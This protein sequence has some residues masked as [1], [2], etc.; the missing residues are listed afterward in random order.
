M[1]R[2]LNIMQAAEN[3]VRRLRQYGFEAYW[4]GGCV[5]D[6]LLEREPK[7]FDVATSAP[8][9][10]I[11]RIFSHTRQVGAKFG[12][13]MVCQG[14]F[15]IETATFRTDLDY[16]D[17][18]HPEQVVFTTAEYDAQRRDFTINGLFYDPLEQK[19]IDYV[20]GRDDLEAGIIR[21]IGDADQR[22]EEDH[23]RLLRAV[24][25]AA[26][27]GFAIEPDT[28]QA[29]RRHAAQI[30]TIS[31][32]RI[33][34]ESEKMFDHHS[35]AVSLG[36]LMDLGLLPHLWPG[37]SVK[38]ITP[39]KTAIEIVQHLPEQADFVLTLAALLHKQPVANVRRIGHDLRCSNRQTD[40]LAWLIGHYARLDQAA[41]MDLASFKKL[42]AHPRFGDLLD[43]NAAVGAAKDVP[44]TSIQ[45]ARHR[46]AEIPLDEIAPLPLV[47]GE[48]LIER[49]LQPGPD[50]KQILDRLYD[51]QLNKQLTTREKALAE[52]DALVENARGT[53]R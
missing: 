52:L 22:F 53:K 21:A 24:R 36:L 12:V 45:A 50:F 17:G 20:G 47:T 30:T 6:M 25:F 41:T 44:S 13:V 26:R 48:D 18:R 19:V 43:L 3:V 35:R 2:T 28:A 23:L 7:D 37:E 33:R 27:F 5:R 32:E 11:M 29:I 51:A 39:P 1:H 16:Q 10:E 49:G 8:P 14:R 34:E 9:A 42:L 4:A 15:W 38:H 40:D 31:P 46:C